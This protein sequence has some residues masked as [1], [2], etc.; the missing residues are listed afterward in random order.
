MKTEGFKRLAVALLFIIPG[1]FLL[2]T[3]LTAV[4]PSTGQPE[5]SQF[6]VVK[7]A[8]LFPVMAIAV[9]AWVIQGFRQKS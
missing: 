8:V 7:F 2:R 3:M 5:T 1:A 6:R 9:I 4:D